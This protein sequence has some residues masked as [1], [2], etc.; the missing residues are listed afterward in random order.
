MIETKVIVYKSVGGMN[1]GV[2]KME[3][4][5]WTVASVQESKEHGASSCLV[6]ILALTIVGLLLLPLLLFS[7]SKNYTVT[8]TRE[9]PE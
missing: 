4:A 2:A 5:G 9:K 7:A 8:F 6:I 3:S 1:S